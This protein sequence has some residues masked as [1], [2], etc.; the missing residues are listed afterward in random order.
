MR[1]AWLAAH[2][3]QGHHVGLVRLQQ[4]DHRVEPGLGRA[5]QVPAD[6]PQACS[7]AA[8]LS[9][10]PPG[11]GTHRDLQ[12]APGRSA[13]AATRARRPFDI[14]RPGVVPGRVAAVE[15]ADD[16]VVEVGDEGR[17]GPGPQRRGRARSGPSISAASASATV[18]NSPHVRRE[19]RLVCGV[20][21]Q[22]AEGVGVLA[23]HPEQ[24]SRP[25]GRAAARSCRPSRRAA[26]D[27]ELL[28]EPR[29]SP[30]RSTARYRSSL[31]V[32]DPVHDEA[33]DAGRRGRR[34]PSRCRRSRPHERG[35]GGPQDLGSTLGPGKAPARRR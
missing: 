17:R 23:R 10:P 13:Q 14:S 22:Q 25:R 28:A 7:T 3:L 12:S 21:P 15:P 35:R 32:E 33:G 11:Q 18:R 8:V 31:V 16:P 1:R 19:G 27:G 2:L 29:R 34:R 4:L 9:P 26:A 5:V 30:A 24:G 6:D 20:D